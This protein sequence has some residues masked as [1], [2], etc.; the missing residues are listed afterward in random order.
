M[1]WPNG[2]IT[3]IVKA[4]DRDGDNVSASLNGL[5]GTP[6]AIARG[7]AAPSAIAALWAVSGNYIPRPVNTCALRRARH[8][9]ILDGAIPEGIP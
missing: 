3:T 2:M 5:L 8:D 1:A 9:C 6:T 7:I 4:T